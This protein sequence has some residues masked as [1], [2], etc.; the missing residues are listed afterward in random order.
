MEEYQ[1]EYKYYDEEAE[2]WNKQKYYLNIPN[3]PCY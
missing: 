2:E 3:Q 1:K